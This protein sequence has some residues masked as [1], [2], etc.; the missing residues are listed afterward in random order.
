[1]RRKLSL[2][3]LILA[4]LLFSLGQP[5]QAQ[6]VSGSYSGDGAATKAITGL[7][8]QP[9]VVIVKGNVAQTAVIRTST[10][11]DPL[12][13]SVDVS[14]PLVGATAMT[15]PMAMIR[16]L[17]ADGFTVGSN[18]AVNQSAITYYWVAFRATPGEMYVGTYAGTGATQTI[19]VGFQPNYVIVISEGANAAVQSSSAMTAG[20]A[21]QFDATNAVTGGVIITAFTATGFQVGTDARA[22]ALGTN[23]HYVAW[24]SSGTM[25]VGFYVG[26]G[27]TPRTISPVGGFTPEYLIVKRRSTTQGVH[28]P[29]SLV[30]D[31]TLTFPAAVNTGAGRIIALLNDAF[32]VGSNSTVNSTLNYYWAAFGRQPCPTVADATHVAASAVAQS[33]QATVYWSSPN[34]V[35]VVRKKSGS[36]VGGPTN[37]KDYNV[38]DPL[39]TDSA[40]F[41][42]FKGVG[43]ETK[44]VDTGCVNGDTC[45][46]KV[47]PKTGSGMIA[48]YA[49]ESGAGN[50]VN[51]TVSSSAAPAWT[52]MMAGGP[53]LK[54]GI[55]GNG[56]IYTSSNAGRIIALNTGTTPTPAATHAWDPIAT[57]TGQLVQGWLTWLPVGG[58]WKYRK[59]ITINNAR[60]SATLTDFPV[61]I[62]LTDTRLQSQAQLSGN[63]IVFTGSD[64]TTRLRHEIE[65]YDGTTG[66]LVAWVKVP[67]VSSTAPTD[68]YMYYGNPAPGLPS[69]QDPANVWDPNFVAVHHLKENPAGAAPQMND[70]TSN[71]NHG[72]TQG[73]WA[74]TAS[75]AAKIGNGLQFNGTNDF[76]KVPESS[77][78]DSTTDGGTFELWINWTKADD[79][80]YQRLLMSSNT[81][82]GPGGA[83]GPEVHG[84]FEWA[85]QAIGNGNGHYFYPW[86][87]PD[88][89]NYNLAPN[90]FVNGQW[91]HLA[92]TLNWSTKAVAIYVDGNPLS[93]TTQNVPTYWTKLAFPN[94]WWWGGT[95]DDPTGY[96]AGVFDEIRVSNVVRSPAYI[97]TSYNN[98]SCPTILIC[99]TPFYTVGAEEPLSGGAMMIGGDQGGR[100]YSVDTASGFKNWEVYL[101]T[102]T[103]P[104]G[105]ADAAQATTVAQIRTWSNPGFQAAYTTDDLIFVATSN[106]SITPIC[107]TAN[108][109]NKLYPLRATNGTVAAALPGAVPWVFNLNCTF[110]VDAIYGIPYVDYPRNRVY[111]TSRAG[112][113]CPAAPPYTSC[114]QS[115]WVID[116]LNASNSANGTRVD[117]ANANA[118]CKLGH[119]QSSVN[120][121]YDATTL[122]VGNEDGYL[123]AI[124]LGNPGSLTT[125]RLKWTAPLNLGSAIKGFVVEDWR[126]DKRLYFSTAD[127]KVWCWQDPGLSATPTKTA[128]SGWPV[129]VDGASWVSVGGAVTPLVLDPT[130][131]VGSSDGKLHKINVDT[132]TDP[133]P[134]CL[135][136]P[137]GGSCTAQLV[138]DLSTETANEIFVSTNEGKIYKL[139]LPL[140]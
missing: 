29:A 22:N 117:C 132:G 17:D 126:R 89:L 94:D 139:T 93:F 51:V 100:V 88:Y 122:Y 66:Q 28:R 140:P 4:G 87:D 105:D 134:Y 130:L 7:G 135:N 59:K 125:P 2:A 25:N 110:S 62:S 106:S 18:A 82:F 21:I 14:K 119:I 32:Q 43:E 9:D 124:D 81:L 26:N 127:G 16:S 23:Y 79:T 50:E 35:L 84:G 40:A 65:K 96:F 36:I 128:C 12:T 44:F 64:G 108:T 33:N 52:Y 113:S 85:I 92:L 20:E 68:I 3:V 24:K 27:A 114:Q 115:L 8:F 109:N 90:P 70:S 91:H 41:V 136:P 34:P 53:I 49:T 76:L 13:T 103:T 55:A 111:V 30:G 38:T 101:K 15:A 121:S 80:R 61:L 60:V 46:Y 138:G 39:T 72:S 57:T 97:T 31:N 63:D 10:M 42:V 11:R 86:G 73:T 131:Y 71:A 37:W 19:T 116:T 6:T 74:P 123:Y 107:G 45:N 5:A 75:V 118:D 56:A 58:E 104:N 99:P 54:A 137:G 1:M 67:S 95:P 98:Q 48:C 112:A 77:S 102:A 120:L 83:G 133:S 78:L 129:Q 69:Q 47:F